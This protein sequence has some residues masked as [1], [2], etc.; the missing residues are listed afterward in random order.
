VFRDDDKA[1]PVFSTVRVATPA[2][3]KPKVVAK[4]KGH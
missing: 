3:A 2:P 1:T 4:A